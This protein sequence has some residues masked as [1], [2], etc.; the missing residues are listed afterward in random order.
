MCIADT[1]IRRAYATVPDVDPT[2]SFEPPQPLDRM[3]SPPSPNTTSYGIYPI[4]LLQLGRAIS[5]YPLPPTVYLYAS[6]LEGHCS[7]G[8]G[9]YGDAVAATNQG[10]RYSF[11]GGRDTDFVTTTTH[12][13]RYSFGGGRYDIVI[14]TKPGRERK[15]RR[16]PAVAFDARALYTLKRHWQLFVRTAGGPN[17]VVV[18][19]A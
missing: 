13:S 7:F 5:R 2:S 11:G 8:G 17:E 18:R 4:K 15:H 12:A 6:S 9:R 19:S 10:G 14:A 3:K 1:Y 16:S